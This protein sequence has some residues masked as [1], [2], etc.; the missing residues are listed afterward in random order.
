VPDGLVNL[1]PTAGDIVIMREGPTGC[2]H[3]VMPWTSAVRQRRTLT[4]RYKSGSEWLSHRDHSDHAHRPKQ[5]DPRVRRQLGLPSPQPLLPQTVA[6][7]SGDSAALA[8][9]AQSALETYEWPAV[10]DSRAPLWRAGQNPSCSLPP[11]GPLTVTPE[12]RFLMSNFG[13]LH[14]RAVLSPTEVDEAR[15]AYTDAMKGGGIMGSPP[16]EQL[17]THPKLLPIYQEFAGECIPVCSP[18]YSR[19]LF[20]PLTNL[21]IRTG[22]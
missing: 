17:I 14:L 1:T 11:A 21:H 22:M 6:L 7:V 15:V 5:I 19:P 13:F 18:V 20:S 3:G 12:M 10:A 16:L 4:M 8:G 2:L 9:F